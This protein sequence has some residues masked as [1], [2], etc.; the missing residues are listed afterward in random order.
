MIA[1]AEM[2]AFCVNIRIRYLIIEELCGLG[3]PCDPPVIE[4]QRS[5][6][7]LQLFFLVKNLY[8]DKVRKLAREGLHSL[9]KQST[10]RLDLRTEQYLHALIREL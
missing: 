7:E 4:V 10:T 3:P 6:E 1:N 2:V 5:A 9:V 8:R